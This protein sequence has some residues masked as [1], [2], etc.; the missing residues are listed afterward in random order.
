MKTPGHAQVLLLLR[1]N[2][3][4]KK[5]N[6]KE[7]KK[8]IDKGKKR[9][10]EKPFGDLSLD[11]GCIGD[12]CT[13]QLEHLDCLF[14]KIRSMRKYQLEGNCLQQEKSRQLLAIH[15]LCFVICHLSHMEP[16]LLPL[17]MTDS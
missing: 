1:R 17:W 14:W 10:A 4:T 7:R 16:F 13:E 8:R 15:F 2:K 12:T 5:K 6:R 9:K 3:K 11:A